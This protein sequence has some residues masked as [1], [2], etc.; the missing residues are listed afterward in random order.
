MVDD[1]ENIMARFGDA[2]DSLENISLKAPTPNDGWAGLTIAGKNLL[3]M[4]ADLLNAITTMS[5][6]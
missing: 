2:R 4:V 5:Q 3:R 1:I 6:S